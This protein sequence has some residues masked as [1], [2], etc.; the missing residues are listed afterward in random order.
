MSTRPHN[1]KKS[2]ILLG[3]ITSESE[4]LKVE[5]ITEMQGMLTDVGWTCENT[6]DLYVDGTA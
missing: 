4:I 3:T 5:N 6:I 2:I 1:I